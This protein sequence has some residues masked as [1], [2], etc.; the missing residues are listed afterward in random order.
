MSAILVAG[1]A[2]AAIHEYNRDQF[3]SIKE[4][5]KLHREQFNEDIEDMKKELE[6]I[7][8]ITSKKID[9]AIVTE[10]KADPTPVVVVEEVVAEVEEKPAPALA[11]SAKEKKPEKKPE[12][13]VAVAPPPPPPAPKPAPAP[14]PPKKIVAKKVVAEKVAPPPPSP[15]PKPTPAAPPAPV[16]PKPVAVTISKKE[17]STTSRTASE[18]LTDLVKQVGKT[19]EKNKEMEDLVK[20]RRVKASVE[21]IDDDDESELEVES[22][23]VMKTTKGKPKKRGVLRKAWRV[24]KKVIAPWRKWDNIS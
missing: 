20:A 8:E 15:A 6:K 2:A 24:T 5:T 22:T 19:V 17:P 14:P 10:E 11:P 3:A 21:V 4:F 13:V 1:T 9:E 18:S 23:T 12:K 7:S 16:D